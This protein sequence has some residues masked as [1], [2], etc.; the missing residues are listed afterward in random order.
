MR[1][2]RLHNKFAIVFH[3]LYIKKIDRICGYLIS[4]IIMFLLMNIHPEKIMKRIL[5][6]SI[7]HVIHRIMSAATKLAINKNRPNENNNEFTVYNKKKYIVSNH[8]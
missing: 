1:Q 2:I 8:F 4:W 7:M 6:K 5:N 3:Y